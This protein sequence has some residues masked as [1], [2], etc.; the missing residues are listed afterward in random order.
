MRLATDAVKISEI[1]AIS[2][3]LKAEY[4]Q[5][6]ANLFWE[7][8][9]RPAAVSVLEQAAALVEEQQ[10]EA[11]GSDYDRGALLSR[12]TS[13][14]E[15][16]AR[17]SAELLQI[18]DVFAAG[19]RSRSRTLLEQVQNHDADLLQRLPPEQRQT[20]E[21]LYL[22]RQTRAASLMRQIAVLSTAPTLADEERRRQLAALHTKLADARKKVVE[23]HRDIESALTAGGVR[24]HDRVPPVALGEFKTWIRDQQAAYLGFVAT[25]R[26]MLRLVILPSGETLVSPIAAD[27]SIASELGL[28]EGPLGPA[29]LRRALD[30]LGRPIDGWL[31]TPT[32]Q[33]GVSDRLALLWSLLVP[34]PLQQSLL[35]DEARRLYIVSAGPL[36]RLPFEALVVESAAQ[37]TYLLDVGPPIIYAPSATLLKYLSTRSADAKVIASVLTL[38]DPRYGPEATAPGS[39]STALGSAAR[40]S[41]STG[42]GL[43]TALPHSGAESRRVADEFG[44]IGVEAQ[45]LTGTEA[46]EANLRRLAGG[47]QVI[48]LACH[49][50]VDG[51]HGNLFG[52]LALSPG[53]GATI[54]PADDGFLTLS[55]AYDLDL[56]RCELAVLSACQT[57]IGP[58]QPGEGAWALSRGFLVA[59]SRRVVA[60]N[61]LVND[62]AAAQLIGG[63]CTGLADAVRQQ[64]VPDFAQSLH[65]AKR[66][67]RGD[68]R[69]ESPYY[70]APFVLLGAP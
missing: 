47:R 21:R 23:S 46:T 43:L 58:Q 5:L 19:E 64:A 15:Q 55:E 50:I 32:P 3:G 20:L 70:W 60:S 48:H 56:S 4:L 44:R 6:Q 66:A 12:S 25:D 8:G 13:L 18:D 30:V 42:G 39:V 24:G 49:G 26:E 35:S 53:G 69:W 10:M 65:A 59:G 27:A 61:W 17:W 37:P 9:D 57:N 36:V 22:A 62:E 67:V 34:A 68:A 1:A 63:F 45:G 51:R 2:P 41:Y 7:T 31:A 52:S 16:L 14:F 11:L 33:P 54:D 40:S 38:G 28:P 29:S